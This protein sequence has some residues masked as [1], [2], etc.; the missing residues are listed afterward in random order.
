MTSANESDSPHPDGVPPGEIHVVDADGI[1]MAGPRRTVKTAFYGALAL[2]SA[3]SLVMG[4]M[5]GLAAG[6]YGALE[7]LSRR[8]AAQ[9]QSSQSAYNGAPMFI[10]VVSPH[11][12]VDSLNVMRFAVRPSFGGGGSYQFVAEYKGNDDDPRTSVV[13]AGDYYGSIDGVVVELR[14]FMAEHRA[15][16]GILLEANCLPMDSVQRVA[17]GLGLGRVAFY[18]APS[19]DYRGLYPSPSL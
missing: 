17:V 13:S 6:Y 16:T 4:F 1:I 19:C 3:A 5:G 2:V 18:A 9:V 14:H 11:E 10:A 15:A 8:P 12:L 7:Q